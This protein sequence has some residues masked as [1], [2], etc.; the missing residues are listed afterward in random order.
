MVAAMI[1]YPAGLQPDLCQFRKHA[2]ASGASAIM[3][4]LL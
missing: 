1:C 2:C 4:H 3:Q